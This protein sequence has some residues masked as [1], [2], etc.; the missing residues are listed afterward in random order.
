MIIVAISVVILCITYRQRLGKNIDQFWNKGS[1]KGLWWAMKA[2]FRYLLFSLC[3]ISYFWE[4]TNSDHVTKENTSPNNKKDELQPN[5]NDNIRSKSFLFRYTESALNNFLSVG[6]TAFWPRK[7]VSHAVIKWVSTLSVILLPIIQILL[8]Y[9]RV[10]KRAEWTFFEIM[11]ILRKIIQLGLF[12][13]GV[14]LGRRYFSRPPIYPKDV[15]FATMPW[16]RFR[17]KDASLRSG[18][19]PR[20]STIWILA[21]LL[22]A[23]ILEAYLMEYAGLNRR[24]GARLAAADRG[25]YLQIFYKFITAGWTSTLFPLFVYPEI[26][27]ICIGCVFI[28]SGRK[29]LKGLLTYCLLISGHVT[30]VTILSLV[31]VWEI[32]RFDYDLKYNLIETFERTENVQN[33]AKR[34][35]YIFDQ[36]KIK[37]DELI[38]QLSILFHY[39]VID[40][41]CFII[42]DFWNFTC[43]KKIDFNVYAFVARHAFQLVLT[44]WVVWKMA[45]FNVTWPYKLIDTVHRWRLQSWINSVDKYKITDSS[46]VFNAEEDDD[47]KEMEEKPIVTSVVDTLGGGGNRKV[48][49]DNDNNGSYYNGSYYNSSRYF[50]D[51]EYELWEQYLSQERFVKR[52]GFRIFGYRVD[53][54]WFTLS[55]LFQLAFLGIGY[56]KYG[57]AFDSIC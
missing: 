49:D 40:R 3:V 22:I 50:L 6:F 44:G 51:K 15:K 1:Y 57:T 24:E 54:R 56:T 21:G 2:F 10:H 28:E 27:A 41:L 52:F 23:C 46:K 9:S 42:L 35:L 20:G 14:Y 25:N 4:E 8:T 18:R 30:V 12:M 43:D 45:R 31:I 47:G 34:R 17:N 39:L 48:I 29:L 7:T 13:Y 32:E 36:I 55:S 37:R 26:V 16:K 19:S 33:T 11:K 53:I 5:S 38:P